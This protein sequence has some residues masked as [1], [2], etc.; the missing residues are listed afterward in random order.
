[1]PPILDVPEAV[2]GRAGESGYLS[3]TIRL[4]AVQLADKGSKGIR[5]NYQASSLFPRFNGPSHCNCTC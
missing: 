4:M 3:H 5:G 2:L 1:M